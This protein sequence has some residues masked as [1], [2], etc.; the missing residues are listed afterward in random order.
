VKGSGQPKF[1]LKSSILTDASN[2][3][4]A[5]VSHA[6]QEAAQLPQFDILISALLEALVAGV[7]SASA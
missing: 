1:C 4:L 7:T 6:A 2:G 5:I 3:K